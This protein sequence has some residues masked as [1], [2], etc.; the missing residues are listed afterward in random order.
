MQQKDVKARIENADRKGGDRIN[1][2]S[3][4]RDGNNPGS[5]GFFYND[6]YLRA[7]GGLDKTFPLE[8][9]AY[10]VKAMN[11]L[12]NEIINKAVSL[13]DP[14]APEIKKGEENDGETSGTPVNVTYQSPK[15]EGEGTAD[16]GPVDTTGMFDATNWK[17][18]NADEWKP[19]LEKGSGK[20]V[21]AI[22]MVV[23]EGF[24]ITGKLCPILG[25]D[26]DY[27]C[28]AEDGLRFITEKSKFPELF[29][30]FTEEKK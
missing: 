15:P 4:D 5:L 22:I 2:F 20:K 13:M 30:E 7:H 3:I 18:Q 29:Q 23:K 12:K 10:I 16:K 21:I 25:K 6:R 26:G 14:E 9:N 17:P 24:F 27:L 1:H 8:F 11:A 19:Y 28:S